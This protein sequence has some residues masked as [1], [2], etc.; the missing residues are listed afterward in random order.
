MRAVLSSHSFV[1]I[2]AFSSRMRSG[3]DSA[4]LFVRIGPAKEPAATPAIVFNAAR[5]L[6]GSDE[7]SIV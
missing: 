2:F 4:A 6:N 1:P 3:L 7:D 5:R